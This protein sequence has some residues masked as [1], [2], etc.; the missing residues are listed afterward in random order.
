MFLSLNGF[1]EA[2]SQIMETLVVAKVYKTYTYV[3]I[4][5]LTSLYSPT[6]QHFLLSHFLIYI[7]KIVYS[8]IFA[9]P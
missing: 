3:L 6:P 7:S 9:P 5:Y 1:W 2:E 8:S 4:L